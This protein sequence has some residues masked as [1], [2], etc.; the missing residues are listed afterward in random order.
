MSEMIIE[1]CPHCEAEIEMKWDVTKH[2]YKAYCP[3][4]GN[5]LMLCD[6]CLNS[7]EGCSCDYNSHTDT[8]HHNHDEI[9]V[10]RYKELYENL[11]NHITELVSGDDL[12]NTL[13]AIGFTDAEIKTEGI[14]L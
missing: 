13:H 12:R 4:C 8:C 10:K 7:D 1:L 11:L 2:G 3:V 6:E 14:E 5:R 9:T